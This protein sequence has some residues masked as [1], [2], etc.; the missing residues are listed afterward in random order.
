MTGPLE[1][2]FFPGEP[3]PNTADDKALEIVIDQ[4]AEL[5]RAGLIRAL[6]QE[7]F[8]DWLNALLVA[9]NTYGH[10]FASTPAGFPDANATFFH[11]GMKAAGTHIFEQIYDISPEHA[12][13]LSSEARKPKPQ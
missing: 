4:K 8:R 1:S 10:T 6:E 7:W 12:L 2:P 13:M 11:L 3:R 9:F 5:R